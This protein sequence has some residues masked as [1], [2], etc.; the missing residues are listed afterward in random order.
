M[1]LSK[2]SEAIEQEA[3]RWVVR[4]DGDLWTA[5]DQAQLDAWIGQDLA[6]RIAYIRLEAT[7]VRCAGLRALAAG[8]EP[9]VIPPTLAGLQFG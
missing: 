2:D 9:G 6:H 1:T 8:A 4:R 3:A 7:W 5:A